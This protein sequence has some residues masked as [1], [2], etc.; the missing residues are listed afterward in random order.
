MDYALLKLGCCNEWMLTL[1]K[2]VFHPHEYEQ[3]ITLTE[4]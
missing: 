4:L 1:N 2:A 3:T